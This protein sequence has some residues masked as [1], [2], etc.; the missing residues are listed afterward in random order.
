M[1]DELVLPIRK[2]KKISILSE[3]DRLTETLFK[4]RANEVKPNS[5][6]YRK[7][8]EIKSRKEE[9]IIRQKEEA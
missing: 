9:R 6:F 8:E 4:P 5:S 2:S 3:L 7:L 1:Q